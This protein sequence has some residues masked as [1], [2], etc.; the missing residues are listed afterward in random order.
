MTAPA[1]PAPAKLAST[2]LLLRDG[3]QGL[4]GFMVVRHHESDFAS[5]ALVFPGGKLAPGDG[6]AEALAQCSGIDG[7]AP[8]AAALRVAAIREAFEECGVLLAR[9][10]GSARLVGAQRLAQLERYR[11]PLDRGEIGIAQ[12]LR[13]EQLELACEELLPFAHWITPVRMP[14]RFD[15]LFFLALPPAEQLAVHDGREAVDSVWIRPADAL[16]Q[17]DAG[18]RTIIPPTRLNIQRLGFSRTVDEA[19]SAARG[20]PVVTVFPELV[21]TPGGPRMRIPLEAGYGVT[22]FLPGVPTPPA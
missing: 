10:R 1:A 7:L 12:M 13:D 4:E 15:T 17:A 19:F 14:K 8:E 16:A 3:A 20:R 11:G 18:Q 2:V 5:G 21:R 6:E 22:E 9:E